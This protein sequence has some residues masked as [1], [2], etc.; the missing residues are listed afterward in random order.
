MSAGFR[1]DGDKK[2]KEHL[3]SYSN[4][5]GKYL[6]ELFFCFIMKKKIG[7]YQ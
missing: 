5:F 7:H 3:N 4:I 1:I 2:T 6:L